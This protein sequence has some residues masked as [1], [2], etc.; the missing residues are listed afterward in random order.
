M[1]DGKYEEA[2]QTLQTIIIHAEPVNKILTLF[3]KVQCLIKAN[4]IDERLVVFYQISSLIEAHISTIKFKDSF[5]HIYKSLDK[6]IETLIEIKQTNCI[7]SLI[8]CQFNLCQNLFEGELLFELE[9]IGF[10][11]QNILKK[12]K[13]QN[14]AEEFKKYFPLMDEIL[15]TMLMI[16]EVDLCFIFAKVWLLLE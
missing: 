2:I 10:N 4:Q 6:L 11:F 9:D 1:N 3:D 15:E 13:S 7:F 14:K 12:L 8:H 5:N 16:T